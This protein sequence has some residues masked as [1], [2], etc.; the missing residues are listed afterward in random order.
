MKKFNLLGVG[1]A[2]IDMQFSVEDSLLT[3]LDLQK[4][5]MDLKDSEN[6]NDTYKKL[7]KKY[8]ESVNACGGSATNTIY[9][10]SILGSKCSFIG[11][12]ANDING[13]LYVD[14]LNNAG[15]KNNCIS[16]EDGISGSCIIMVSPD[17]ERTMSTFLGISSQLNELDISEE[18]VSETQIVYLEGYL[19]TSD[20]C[21]EAANKII[22]L[23]KLNNTKIA[24][25][26]SDPNIVS[27][28]KERLEVWMKEKI[29]YLFCNE[30]EAKTFASTNDLS[31]AKEELIKYSKTVFIT[32]G[33]NGATIV[34]ANLDIKIKG[35]KA[36]AIDTNGAGDMF[37]G[38][39]LNQLI[40]GESC[41]KAAEFGCY[42]A[43]KGVENYGPRL[44]DEEYKKFQLLFAEI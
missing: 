14:N 31:Q 29:D 24:V 15:I 2:L 5:T 26:L 8:G 34:T 36:K 27:A 11:K 40:K 23:A 21:N 38:A 13:N 41:Q 37:A 39:T 3:E 43:S 7:N 1:A 22:K 20:C 44:S 19:V 10:A 16:N 25:S 6:Q 35:F 33:S 17:A 4:G 9:A 12:V 32:E 28:F 18:M 30:E 42:L